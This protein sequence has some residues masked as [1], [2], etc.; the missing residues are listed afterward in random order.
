MKSIYAFI[1]CLI[2]TASYTAKA[3]VYVSNFPWTED[4]EGLSNCSNTCTASCPNIGDFTQNGLRHW[5]VDN[6]GTSSFATGPSVDQNPGN[7]SGKYIYSETSFPCNGGSNDW[8]ALSPYFDFSDT[9]GGYQLKF[10]WHAYG[11][12][13]GIAHLDVDTTTVGNWMLDVIPSWTDNLDLWQQEAVDF[14]AYK[15]KDSVRFRIRYSNPTSFTG[16]FA[17]DNFSLSRLLPEDVYVSEIVNPTNPFCDTTSQVSVRICNLG[18]NNLTSFNLDHTV[19]GVAGTTYNWTGNLTTGSCDTVTISTSQVSFGTNVTFYSSLPNGIMEPNPS[20]DTIQ[21]DYKSGMSGTYQI[22][23]DFASFSEAID[24][25]IS[26]GVCGHVTIIADTGTYVEQISIPE[27]L[28]ADTGATITFQ[29][30]T[31][32]PS[33][34]VLSYDPSSTFSQEGVLTLDGTDYMTFK[35]MTIDNSSNT[36]SYGRVIN[37]NEGSTNNSFDNLIIDGSDFNTSSTNNALFFANTGE[38]SDNSITNSTLIHGSYGIY[39]YGISNKHNNGLTIEDNQFESFYYAAIWIYYND[40]L[41]INDNSIWTDTPFSSPY[42]MRL[43]ECDRKVEIDN[44]TISN[45]TAANTNIYYGIYLLNCDGL[46]TDKSTVTNNCLNLGYAGGTAFNYGI[47]LSNTGNFN[48]IHNSVTLLNDG[49]SGYA[50]YISGGGLIQSFNNSF[51]TYGSGVASYVTT[52]F[53]LVASN[54][55]NFYTNG[56]SLVY[57]GTNYAS[58]NAY[59]TGTGL[60]ANSVNT[61]PN[62]SNLFDCVTCNDTLNNAGT[63]TNIATDIYGTPRDNSSPDIGAYEFM[64]PEDF[65]FES[66]SLALCSGGSITL[67]GATDGSSNLWSTGDTTSS[68]QVN[69]VGVYT[70]FISGSCGTFRDTVEIVNSNLSVSAALTNGISCSGASD[71]EVTATVAGG[72]GPFS[73][74]WS[75]GESTNT[76]TGL[77]SGTYTVTVSDSLGCTAVNS[78][79][80]TS[81]M[82]LTSGLSIDSVISCNGNSDGVLSVTPSGGTSPYTYLWSNSATTNVINNLSAAAYL[83]TVTDANGCSVIDATAISEPS[84]LVAVTAVDSAVSCNGASDGGA[85]V[86]IVGGTS[87]YSYL[88]SNAASTA[89]L[90]GVAAGTYTV[91]VTDNN[92]CT[93]S[94]NVTIGEPTAMNLIATVISN[95]SCNSA[96]DGS[97]SANASGGTAPYS[98][99]WSSSSSGA[100]VTNLTAGTYTVTATDANG[101]TATANVTVTDP[102]ALSSQVNTT[103]VNCSGANN[104]SVT[105]TISGGSAPYTYSWNNPN[106]AGNS[107]LTLSA[108]TYI[109]TVTDANGCQLIDTAVVGT[110]NTLPAINLGNDTS[111][112]IGDTIM[113]NA[114]AFSSYSWSTGANTPIIS[115]NGVGSYWVQVTDANGCINRD[116]ININSHPAMTLI[117]NTVFETCQFDATGSASVNIS[118]G[119]AP[120]STLWND[121]AAQTTDTAINLTNGNYMVNVIDAK[122]CSSQASAFVGYSFTQPTVDLGADTTRIC[123]GGSYTATPGAGFA[124]YLWSTGDT[125]AAITV[126]T[127]GTYSVTATDGN[128]CS[129][130]DSMVLA[131]DVCVGLNDHNS[132][133]A[134]RYYPNPNDGN[135]QFSLEGFGGKNAQLTIMNLQ[136][137]IIH[138]EQLNNMPN[139]FNKQF[140]L[141]NHAKGIYLMSLRTKDNKWVEKI[142]IQ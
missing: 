85:S 84:A 16:D 108:G 21:I 133:V 41:E 105:A 56:T 49:G 126:S 132:A 68:I 53:A 11:G 33:D 40:N 15:G 78:V 121:N 106:I 123:T 69:S 17:L 107:S 66:D 124:N 95:V 58:L 44:N 127:A 125:T 67:T 141:S 70:L 36:F 73:Y 25:L 122:G 6:G 87:P 62:F 130:S 91:T 43:L 20:N 135:F 102:S 38:L 54:N 113:L 28:G 115:V 64:L 104:G 18:T 92:G 13:M 103:D 57:S 2:F 109:L 27:I 23:L 55:N 86:S 116:T 90:T 137:K 39:Y 139:T 22:P 19:N 88:W 74:A 117:T 9:T 136:G 1:L 7:S 89:S 77:A 82:M 114:G 5:I 29:G 71:G 120:F 24:S 14:S 142:I 45:D 131:I 4:F 60:D 75:S 35:D 47:Y 76:I 99:S 63:S 72:S 65:A 118:G 50:N 98:Y 96:S 112:C 138:D 10:W 48:I 46:A 100:T 101:C 119:T 26:L 61:D 128:G 93:A 31:G 34:V 32:N 134:M 42:G 30:A 81:P 94:A 52:P 79:T 97:A 111:F 51:T 8:I 83:V 37:L 80:V 129:S 59:Q 140:D 110:L 3:Q 12:T